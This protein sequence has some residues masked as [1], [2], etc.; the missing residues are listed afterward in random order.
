MIT[1]VAALIVRAGRWLICQR[2]KGDAL[3]LQWE[4]PGGKV[5]PGETLQQALAR[6]LAEELGVTAA[7]GREAWRTQFT[8]S[9]LARTVELIFFHA[10]LPAVTE[11]R[12]LA[13]EQIAWVLPEEL[14]ACDF[15]PADRELVQLIAQGRLRR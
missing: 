7:I 3:E 4:F 14:P 1:V 8:Y 10:E 2:R 13:F 12:N 9:N 11:P 5:Q 6:E 15:L